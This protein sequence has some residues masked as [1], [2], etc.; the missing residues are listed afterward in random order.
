MSREEAITTAVEHQRYCQEAERD[1]T[2]TIATLER[3]QKVQPSRN[4]SEKQIIA[5]AEELMEQ[6]RNAVDRL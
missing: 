6:A 5:I 2:G 4:I 1:P 3:A